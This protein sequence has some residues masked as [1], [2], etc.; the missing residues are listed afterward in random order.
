MILTHV[1][2]KPRLLHQKNCL[3]DE[4]VTLCP[5]DVFD[6]C[7]PHSSTKRSD[8]YKTRR[9]QKVHTDWQFFDY[10]RKL[11]FL[12]IIGD[13]VAPADGGCCL[14]SHQ[15]FP[16]LTWAT[17]SIL[18]TTEFNLINSWVQVLIWPVWKSV[19]WG[20]QGQIE[21]THRVMV[22]NLSWLLGPHGGKFWPR[23]WDYI[24]GSSKCFFLIN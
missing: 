13:L 11:N 19:W 21:K 9:C 16:L 7:T 10:K 15:D 4:E 5:C 23:L 1:C 24:L 22:S 14:P 3:S 2:L 18:P 17:V 20:F 6:S 12:S 8:C